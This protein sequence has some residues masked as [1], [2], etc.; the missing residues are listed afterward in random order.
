MDIWA[1][2]QSRLA[3]DDSDSSYERQGAAASQWRED[4]S[5]SYQPENVHQEHEGRHARHRHQQYEDQ[6]EQYDGAYRQHGHAYRPS[7][8]LAYPEP[9]YDGPDRAYLYHEHD[10]AYREERRDHD[11]YRPIDASSVYEGAYGAQ[12]ERYG[13]P[14]AG[15]ADQAYYPHDVSAGRN[16]HRHEESNPQDAEAEEDRRHRGKHSHGRARPRP[17][18]RRRRWLI[19]VGGLAL[20]ALLCALAFMWGS[21]QPPEGGLPVSAATTPPDPSE[22][23]IAFPEVPSTSPSSAAPRSSSGT[24]SAT[25]SLIPSLTPSATPRVTSSA[26]PGATPSVTPTQTPSSGPVLLG[27][28]SSRGVANMAQRYCDRYTG[29]SAEARNDGRWQ[30]TKLLS[31]SIVDMG[32]ACRDTYDSGAYARTSNP[33]DPYAWRCYR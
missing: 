17:A 31:A 28:S 32:I 14:E 18:S 23:P 20:G 13:L 15:Y 3:A 1:P 33:G 25:P 24:P 7:D 12:Q 16:E 22:E 29:G 26:T 10:Q 11:P 4:L 19:P 27:P 6:Y 8:P 21:G 30:C 9:E 2:R 5:E